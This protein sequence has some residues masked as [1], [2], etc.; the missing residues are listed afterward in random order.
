MSGYRTVLKVLAEQGAALDP[1]ILDADPRIVNAER[2]FSLVVMLMDEAN[3]LNE[4]A[5]A[6]KRREAARLAKS[7]AINLMGVLAA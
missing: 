4:V 2:R 1:I 5:A 6:D 3:N 7:T